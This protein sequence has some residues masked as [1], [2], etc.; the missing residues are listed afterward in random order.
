MIIIIKSENGFSS[1]NALYWIAAPTNQQYIVY[2][3]R[4]FG[5]EYYAICTNDFGYT[6][7]MGTMDG[8]YIMCVRVDI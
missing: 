2:A 8:M 1:S 7:T 5:T 4:L 3:F 6:K